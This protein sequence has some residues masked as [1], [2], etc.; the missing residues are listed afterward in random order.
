[1]SS[2]ST[3]RNYLNESLSYEPERM[4][5]LEYLKYGSLGFFL[6][7]MIVLYV[8]E[9]PYFSNTFGVQR[10]VFIALIVGIGIGAGI[11][12][13]FRKEAEDLTERI[14]I[15]VFFIIITMIFMPLLAS[16]SNRLLSFQEVVTEQVTFVETIPFFTDRFGILRGEKVQPNAFNTFFYR[17]NDLCYIRT[18]TNIYVGATPE[19]NI[20]IQTREG[21]WGF[22]YAIISMDYPEF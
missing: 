16:L 11:G 6:L 10:L 13:F 15:Y 18:K 9:F 12:Y 20:T 21:F 22:D 8:F 7:A 17:E 14:Q 1:M 4:S 3:Y 2:T 19:Q 5:R